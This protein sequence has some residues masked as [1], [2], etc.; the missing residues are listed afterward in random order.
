VERAG[1]IE[2]KKVEDNKWWPLVGCLDM[3]YSVKSLCASNITDGYIKSFKYRKCYEVELRALRALAGVPGV[4]S[5][6]AFSEKSFELL[7]KPVG[8]PL[9]HHLDRTVLLSRIASL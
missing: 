9:R 2:M 6:I 7:T 3:A 5:L 4:P 1:D 8:K